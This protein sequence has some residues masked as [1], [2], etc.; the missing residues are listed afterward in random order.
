MRIS[1]WSSD[2]CSSDLFIA[3]AEGVINPSV[4]PATRIY[5]IIAFHTSKFGIGGN[6]GKTMSRHIDLGHN[7]HET[8]FCITNHFPDLFLRIIAAV[9]G[10]FSR[11]RRLAFPPKPCTRH[12]PGA[13]GSQFW[14]ALDLD[15]PSLVISQVPVKNI[16]FEFRELVDV[17]FDKW[18]R[19]EVPA[20]VQ[21]QSPP[22]KTREIGDA[23]TGNFPGG[24]R[25][26][27]FVA[28]FRRQ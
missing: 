21:H 2:V 1:D 4:K 17:L 27:P 22:L 10:Q 20:D 5:M 14:Q 6:G 12:P 19:K 13:H 28:N 18:Y 24:F 25:Y 11:L 8:C 3:D 23:N 15:A 9:P 16:H 26:K 7:G